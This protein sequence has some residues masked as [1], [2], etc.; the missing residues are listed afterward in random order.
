MK[1]WTIFI[2]AGLL[3]CGA[4]AVAAD[5]TEYVND[6]FEGPVFPPAGWAIM[7]NAPAYAWG[8]NTSRYHTGQHSAL[9][10][11]SPVGVVQDEWLVTPA[12]NT[13]GAT[14]VVLTFWESAQYWNAL[15]GDHHY[16]MVSTTSQTDPAAYSVLLD[17]TPATHPIPATWQQVTL[18]LN[19]YVGQPTL[20]VA[21][22]YTDHGGSED[23]WWVDDVWIRQVEQHDVKV[24]SLF[25]VEADLAAGA[26]FAPQA[27]VQNI[28][29]A[30]ETFDVT[31]T[32]TESGVPAY[33]HTATVTALAAGQFQ[34]VTFPTYAV[35]FGNYLEVAAETRLSGDSD[36]ANDR[37]HG[38]DYAYTRTRIPHGLFV[39]SWDCSGCPEANAALDAYLASGHE[40]DTALMRVHCWWP[41]GG[42]DPMYLANVEQA[43]ALIEGTLTGSDY[44]PHLWI[45]GYVDA[46]ADGGTF[47][48]MFEQR[49][50][51]GAPVTL[52]LA[53]EPQSSQLQVTVD[54]AEPLVPNR[55]YRLFAAITEDN[56]YAAGTNGEVWHHQVFRHLYP[57]V[58]GLPLATALG[59]QVL[60][61]PTPLGPDWVYENLRLAVYVMDVTT[62]RVLNAATAALPAVG[63]PVAEPGLVTTRLLGATPNPCNPST[64]ITF[65]TGKAGPVRLAIYD[66][67]GREV[68]ELLRSPV[69]P[70]QHAVL[71]RGC[72][73]GGREVSS[74]LYFVRFEAGGTRE[75][76][77]IALLR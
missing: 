70:G 32:I 44:A 5:R 29:T 2:A 56:I 58:V 49:R 65:T 10:H 12:M 51:I 72:D 77:K 11:Y 68:A 52:D 50:Q 57:D 35:V 13:V 14:S 34:T 17:M 30:A 21:L 15:Y 60:E 7:T 20:Y 41:G 76:H 43:T 1:R 75:T 25:P 9:V 8:Q 27:V 38:Y 42:D 69:A 28:G 46:D 18:N 62:H 39:T 73:A 3:A 54:V 55:D 74:G 53:Y 64:T 45:D 37:R 67:R 47:A 24:F 36:P 19:A 31:C 26:S 63:T 40:D 33:E 59:P 23:N 22:R 16:I 48:T 61:I 4:A 71:W 66:V 6:G